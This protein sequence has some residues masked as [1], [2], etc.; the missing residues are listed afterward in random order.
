[1]AS[2][3]GPKFT[4][5]EVVSAAYRALL[6][7]EPD[8]EGRQTHERRL[9]G[10]DSLTDVLRGF[11]GSPEFTLNHPAILVS[12]ES[13]PKNLIQL[14]LSGQQRARVWQ[15]VTQIWSRL[16]RE[17]P[18]F[19]VMT[20]E[21]YRLGKMSPEAI[22]RFYD[23]GQVDIRRIEGALSRHG[24]ELPRDGVCIDY[25]C[26]LG[27]VTLWLAR[28]C[29]RV[30]AVDVSAAH[31]QIAQRE[32]AARGV[33]NVEFRLLRGRDDLRVL[34]GAD[35]F[36]SVIVLQHNPPPIIA[37]ILHHA[38]NGLKAGGAAFFQ[39]PTYGLGYGWN[40]DLFI[41]RDVPAGGME[42][43]VVPQQVVFRLAAEAGCVPVEV[44]PDGCAG[45]PNWVSNTF[46]FAKP[47]AV[48]WP[49]PN[50]LFAGRGTASRLLAR[51]TAAA[52]PPRSAG[53]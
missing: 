8:E 48:S 9:Q 1:M 10:G 3:A 11:A 16:G 4:A 50:R 35:L 12:H 6:G 20:S 24:R 25:G 46:L 29:K 15:H 27:R 2:E 19:S 21:Q 34:Q 44:L 7:R 43:H 49:R 28:R 17:D 52:L 23:S 36:H 5:E 26:G 30:I 37:D 22:E 41:A 51:L 47:Q 18:Y 14:R 33:S 13:L 40:Y 45:M 31:L 42:M 39:V 53:T 38:L 32:L